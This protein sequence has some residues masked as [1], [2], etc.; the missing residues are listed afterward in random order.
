MRL[1]ILTQ[2]V[3]TEDIFLGF[4]VE[5]VAALALR[6]ESIEVICLKE[7]KHSLPENVNVQSLG[8]EGGRSRIK[9][10]LRFWRYA[11]SLR[12]EYDAVFVHMNEEYVLLG[13]P[14]WQ[15]LKKP[16]YLWRNHHTGSFRTNIAVAWSYKVFC[17][18][19]HSYT[20][21]FKKTLLMPVGV[22]TRQ[23][24]AE[25]SV[26]RTPHSILFLGRIA[27]SKRPELLIAALGEL[28][29][30]GV[31][32]VAT[33][34]GSPL[35]ADVGYYQQLQE[36]ARTLGIADRVTFVPGVPHNEAPRIFQRH[37]IFV[38]LSR[39]GMYD[40]TIFEA[41]AS[42]CIV[43]ASSKDFA[44]DAGV[45]FS[46]E[47]DGSDLAGRLRSLLSLTDNKRDEGRIALT[48]ISAGNSL[49]ALTDQLV[50]EITI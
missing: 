47:E 15:I 32:Y 17:T 36:Q 11:W 4:F 19:A 35:P 39:S 38:N 50:E 3:D 14:L 5:W 10:I 41:A 23:F 28:A 45:Q 22:D 42:G 34:C 37:E 27:A 44:H 46:F 12:H 33:F 9:Y 1:L 40:K 20:A 7:G 2:A 13:A 24:T 8:K 6:F 31:E 18:S 25:S 49:S 30:E 26:E 21:R 48:A 43:L 29:R 16:V